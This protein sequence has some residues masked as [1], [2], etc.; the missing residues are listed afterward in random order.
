M[1]SRSLKFSLLA[2]AVLLGFAPS[3]VIAQ[4]MNEIPARAK[5]IG[6]DEK[7][8]GL[9]PLDLP[10]S[11]EKGDPC[12]V[13]DL[14]DG[15]LPVV[16]TLNYS[17]CPGLCVAQLDG[18]VAGVN[19]LRDLRLGRDFRLLS[20]SIDPRETS[21]KAMGRRRGTRRGWIRTT[22]K[23]LGIFGLGHRKALRK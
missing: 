12:K 7:L 9:V 13:G 8:G 15:K 6:V 14:F 19:D 2:I 23:M 11:N 22:R 21:E 3:L 5:G 20:I 18:L 17:G 4:Y 16:L 10:F 1:P